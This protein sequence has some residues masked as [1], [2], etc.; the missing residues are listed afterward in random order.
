MQHT[1]QQTQGRWGVWIGG[2]LVL[3]MM[4]L[5]GCGSTPST[6]TTGTTGTTTA[7]TATSA[8]P[9]TTSP[10]TTPSNGTQIMISGTSASNF[11]FS[12]GTITIK[13]GTTIVW[14]NMSDAPHT[15]TSDP[16]SPVT[17]D[18]GPL[19]TNGGTFSMTFSTPGT[20]HYH[21]SIHPFMHGTI[22]VTP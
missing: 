21:C 10:S 20:Y 19:N 2:V 17:W 9:A 13:A 22:V 8:P 14:T 16:G 15:S 11:A 6:G 5:S 3:G 18:S 4:L 1:R 12:P 7:P